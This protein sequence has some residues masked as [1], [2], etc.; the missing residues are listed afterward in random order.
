MFDWPGACVTVVVRPAPCDFE[1]LALV[2]YAYV[3]ENARLLQR[4]TWNG[5]DRPD[6]T[7]PNVEVRLD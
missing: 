6:W 7:V 4:S 1:C 2:E 3:G 5:E